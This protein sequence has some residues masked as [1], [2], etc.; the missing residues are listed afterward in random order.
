MNQED[1]VLS[2]KKAD[3][4]IM[5]S[6]A[7]SLAEAT[8]FGCRIITIPLEIAS[9]DHQNINA[10]S[11]KRTYPDTIILKETHLGDL[12]QVLRSL[13]DFRK[14]TFSPYTGAFE[15][16]VEILESY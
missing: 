12:T 15:R 16:T 13:R 8:L 3:I 11:W 4:A 10:L 14:D 5:R 1:L 2:Y 6:S 7:N 9:R